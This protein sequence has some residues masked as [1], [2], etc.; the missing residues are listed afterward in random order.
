MQQYT[1]AEICQWV[2]GELAGNGNTRISGYAQLTEVQPGE[3]SFV[4]SA[5]HAKN[6]A[7]CP[8]A[9]LVVYP[10]FTETGFNVIKVADPQFAFIEI[11]Q[12]LNPVRQSLPAGIH[13]SVII[14]NSSSVGKNAAIGPYVV[15]GADCKIGD[16]CV[17]HPGVVIEDGVS[18]GNDALIY[19]N[20]VVRYRSE[21]GS[22]VILHPGVVI[23]ADGFGFR[24][25]NGIHKKIPQLG[26]VVIEDDV[27]IGANCAIDRGAIGA[28]RIGKGTKL[29]NL[30]QVAH[31][32][33]IGQHTVIAAQTGISGSCN[34]GNGVVLAGQVGIADHL[35]IEDRVIVTAQS[36]VTKSIPARTIVSG[37]PARHHM[38]W[39]R[40]E[41]VIRKLPELNKIIQQ[42]VERIT[43]LEAELESKP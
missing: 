13:A 32:V 29:D 43:R 19:G 39:K 24:F 25:E 7:S 35:S 41:A 30:I 23:G 17:I 5:K 21:I 42:L 1:L 37:Y 2:N 34:I 31:N 38:Q 22:R 8:A 12:R 36:G 28:T 40:E 14:G 10:E 16:N 3:I 27:E 11:I 26:N 4:A 15:I 33:V 18:I 9:A 20:V 6:L